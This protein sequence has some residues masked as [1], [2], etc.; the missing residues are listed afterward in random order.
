VRYQQHGDEWIMPKR[1]GYKM[2]CCDCRL[3][4]TMDFRIKDGRVQF[5]P[6]RD[7]RATAASRRKV[8]E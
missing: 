3:V 1:R 8:K 2:R 5:K 7:E 6:R 4:H